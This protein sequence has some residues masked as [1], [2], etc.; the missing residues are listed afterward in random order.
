MQPLGHIAGVGAAVVASLSTLV[1]V[2]LG[3]LVGY[4]F[5]GTLYALIASYALFG[6][7]ALAAMK[8]A[9]GGWRPKRR[10]VL[11]K[12]SVDL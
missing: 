10:R 2:P 7:G 12:A 9:D 1:S 5:D 6:A 8:W 11:R 3:A 4:T